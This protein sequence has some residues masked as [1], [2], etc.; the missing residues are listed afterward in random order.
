[1]ERLQAE[2]DDMDDWIVSGKDLLD[3]QRVSLKYFEEPG[4]EFPNDI[5]AEKK[6]YIVNEE[7]IS[8]EK[9]ELLIFWKVLKVEERKIVA[10]FIQK[11]DV[12]ED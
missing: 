12:K 5:I 11:N 8:V 10:V 4:D 6:T 1:M 3:C 9:K 2:P 7:T